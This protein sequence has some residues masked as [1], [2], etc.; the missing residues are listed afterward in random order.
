MTADDHR[1]MQFSEKKRLALIYSGKVCAM[2]LNW[3]NVE[4]DEQDKDFEYSV[5]VN[6]SGCLHYNSGP[7]AA[8]LATGPLGQGGNLL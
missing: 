2:C 8:C 6:M 1:D 3:L 7:F 4:Q 5:W